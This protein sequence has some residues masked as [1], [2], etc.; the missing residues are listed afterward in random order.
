MDL[1]HAVGEKSK[2]QSGRALR[3]PRR[4]SLV[5]AVERGEALLGA[6]SEPA[7]LG[8][9]VACPLAVLVRPV[10]GMDAAQVAEGVF[11]RLNLA[12]RVGAALLFVFGLR[13]GVGNSV[14]RRRGAGGQP[15]ASGAG[16]PCAFRGS[17]SGC[18]RRGPAPNGGSRPHLR[19]SA[20]PGVPCA[21]AAVASETQRRV[22]YA[23][24][25]QGPLGGHHSR[26][27]AGGGH[28]A[29]GGAPNA[30]ATVCRF[31]VRA[32]EGGPAG[33][34]GALRRGR[35]AA[36]GGERRGAFRR[37]GSFAAP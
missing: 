20:F 17:A 24:G 4:A 12:Q 29:P 13:A 3:R 9:E 5:E 23:A 2:G 25:S 33:L 14:R 31:E 22:S 35:G 37:R 32:R 30:Q 6:L 15:R 36:A 8:G 28:V 34:P 27:L 1:L 7:H 16:W 11:Q 21:S 10:A 18:G 19:T 26:Q